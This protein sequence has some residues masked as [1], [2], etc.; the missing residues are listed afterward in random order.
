MQEKQTK[1]FNLKN[2]NFA[3]RLISGIGLFF[4]FGLYLAFAF[5]NNEL[6]V[7]YQMKELSYLFG[8]LFIVMSMVIL[9]LTF[10]ELCNT[11]KIKSKLFKAFFPIL[12]CLL[13]LVPVGTQL[14]L[15]DGIFIYNYSRTLIAVLANPFLQ[16]FSLLAVIGIMFF[17]LKLIKIATIDAIWI[18]LIAIIIVFGIK[19]FTNICLS[20]NYTEE[21]NQGYDAIKFG[22]LTGFWIWMG[23]I[24]TDSFAYVFGVKFGKHKIAPVISPQKSWEGA[25]GGFVSSIIILSAFA[26]AIYFSNSD[27]KVFND[28]NAESFGKGRLITLYVLFAILISVVCQFGDLFFS[29]VKRKVGIKDFS[30][31]IPG[32]GGVLDR[33]DSFMIVFC[34]IFIMTLFV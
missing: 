16:I 2:N 20:V 31:L 3:L 28:Y 30:N 10:F 19:G 33:L 14:V 8:G 34:L 1:P 27:Y 29:F 13:Y 5:F 4:I 7:E 12:G 32:H 9:F 17:S 26:F 21:V 25:I 15:E 6:W 18:T 24:L 23:I 22:Y 11:F